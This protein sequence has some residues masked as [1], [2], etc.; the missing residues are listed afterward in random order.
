MSEELTDEQVIDYL[1]EDVNRL[2]TKVDMLEMA[3]K[4]Q[5]MALM[6]VAATL[7]HDWAQEVIGHLDFIKQ[8]R[9]EARRLAE[10]DS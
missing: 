4:Q 10:G 3:Y 7:P 1:L 8:A 9:D 2:T 6:T 5:W